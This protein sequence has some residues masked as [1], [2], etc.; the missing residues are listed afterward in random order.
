VKDTFSRRQ[1]VEY[2]C[3]A[4]PLELR[5]AMEDHIR[6]CADCRAIS[7]T[8]EDVDRELVAAVTVFRDSVSSVEFA[9]DRAYKMWRQERLPAW[10][11]DHLS[12]RIVRLQLFLAPI[13]G[14]GTAERAMLAAASRSTAGSVE[15]L[16][17]PQWPAF[18][19]HLSSIVGGLCGEPSAR[20]LWHIGQPMAMEM[21]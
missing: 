17:E 15:L 16:T 20:L 4:A 8:F 12:R 1:W 14:F 11:T 19:K 5:A 13:C 9:G 6:D 2:T 7:S 21:S 3:G 10:E 18:V